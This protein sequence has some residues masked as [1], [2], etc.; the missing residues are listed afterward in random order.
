MNIFS[1]FSDF[2]DGVLGLAWVGQPNGGSSG[3]ICEGR[4]S[5]SIGERSLNTA[6]GSYLNYGA[7]QPRGVVTITVAHEFGH[8]F[9]S[10][11]SF[12]PPSLSLLLLFHSMILILAPVLLVVVMVTI[13]CIQ[14]LLTALKLTM[15]SFHLVQLT[16][17]GL[18]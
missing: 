6:I 17:Y 10:S 2:S 4:V 18:Y 12:L 16:Q 3:G 1:L 5:L 15:T 13:S 11:A 9:G 8:N 14:E 7:R